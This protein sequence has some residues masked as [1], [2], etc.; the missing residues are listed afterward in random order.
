MVSP[1]V[2][3]RYTVLV[4]ARGPQKGQMKSQMLRV[5]SH[6]KISDKGDFSTSL[7]AGIYR[8]TVEPA[9]KITRAEAKDVTIKAGCTIRVVLHVDTGIR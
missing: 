2:Y 8:I 9:D 3:R 7:P 5:V 1:E 6:L 4:S